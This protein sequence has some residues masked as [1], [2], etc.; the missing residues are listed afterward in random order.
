MPDGLNQ[1]D[2]ARLYKKVLR[3]RKIMFN[4]VIQI[5][6]LCHQ[7]LQCYMPS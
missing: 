4:L 5:F 6:G 3:I 2:C 7:I 1:T